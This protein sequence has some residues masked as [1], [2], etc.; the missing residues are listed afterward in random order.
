MRQ[1]VRRGPGRPR[2]RLGAL[3]LSVSAGAAAALI[4]SVVVGGVAVPA[5]AASVPSAPTA[6]SS[7]AGSYIVRARPGQLDAVVAELRADG[8]RLGRRIGIIDAVVADLPAGA[9]DALREN[10]QVASITADAAVSLLNTTYVP[11]QD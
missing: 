8:Y 2:R 9:V 3:R 4:A 7:P 5:G 10:R 11:G 1:S 6:G